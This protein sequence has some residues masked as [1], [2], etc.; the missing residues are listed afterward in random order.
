M[1]SRVDA[2]RGLKI[3][4]LVEPVEPSAEPFRSLRVALELVPDSRRGNLMLFTSA[5]PGEGKST[6][7]ANYALV[8]AV[9]DRRVLLVDADLRHPHVHE[10]FGIPRSPGLTE[11]IYSRLDFHA[12][13]QPIPGI[14]GLHVLTA[15][16]PTPRAGDITG[17]NAVRDLLTKASSEYD[18]VAIDSPPVLVGAD[19][20]HIAA[21]PAANVVFVVT[22]KQG[23]RRVDRAVAKLEL[24]G[25]NL[26]G[27]VVNREGHLSD[28]GY[29]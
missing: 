8:S 18:I 6:I 15:G 25:G 27:F 19:A 11:V 28:Y 21:H 22:K 20:T 13:T 26:L 9:N 23:T 29:D 7:A 4:G 16:L 3:R 17:S 14:P 24:L 10:I 1:A 2:P 12:L 5:D